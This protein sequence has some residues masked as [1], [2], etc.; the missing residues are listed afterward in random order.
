MNANNPYKVVEV[1]PRWCGCVPSGTLF[2]LIDECA[3]LAEA[4]A[5]KTSNS[6]PPVVHNRECG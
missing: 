2:E 6:L 3:T 1:G 5:R 4:Q